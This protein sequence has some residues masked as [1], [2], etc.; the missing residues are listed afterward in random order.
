MLH[1]ISVIGLNV[2]KRQVAGR[3]HQFE[4]I[5]EIMEKSIG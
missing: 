5:E 2:A 3:R 1:K 4:R